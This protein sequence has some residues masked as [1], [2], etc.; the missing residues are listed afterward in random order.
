MI[1]DHVVSQFASLPH[2]VVCCVLLWYQFQAYHHSLVFLL[3]RS[4]KSLGRSW[5][6]EQLVDP[7]QS[8]TDLRSRQ[9]DNFYK[10]VPQVR[11]LVDIMAESENLLEEVNKLFEKMDLYDKQ[12]TSLGSNIFNVQSQADL[13]M[14]MIQAL[15]KEQVLLH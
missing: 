12:L 6:F 15:Q 7:F 10:L 9:H 5:L 4:V 14:W 3:I 8:W 13:S 11:Y 2:F 1:V